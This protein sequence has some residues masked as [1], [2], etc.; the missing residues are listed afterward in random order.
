MHDVAQVFPSAD[1]GDD[2]S[3][4]QAELVTTKA[5]AYA[6]S[7]K[8]VVDQMMMS[9]TNVNNLNFNVPSD[10]AYDTAPYTNKIFHPSGGGLSVGTKDTNLFVST[11][12]TPAAGWYMNRFNN[13]GWTPT[14]SND[15]LLTAYGIKKSVCE[16]INKK[17]TGKTDIPAVTGTLAAYFVKD[18]GNTQ[19]TKNEC[20]ACEGY[21]TLCVTNAGSTVYVYYNIISG[22]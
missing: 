20:S 21:P 18:N 17:I 3:G 15:V 9:G 7:A 14:A 6:G 13:I 8:S 11:A 12:L 22:Q 4:D 1:S 5:V 2:L 19:L 10:A 16:K